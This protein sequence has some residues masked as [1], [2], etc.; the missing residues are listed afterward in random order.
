MPGPCSPCL[1]EGRACLATTE[2]NG[3]PLCTECAAFETKENSMNKID[4]TASKILEIIEGA[5]LD[6]NEVVEVIAK[7]TGWEKKTE[8]DLI[9]FDTGVENIMSLEEQVNKIKEV[10]EE[11]YRRFYQDYSGRGM[12]GR[13]CVGI[14]CPDPHKVIAEV[15]IKGAKTDS[16][17]LDSIVYWPNIKMPE[18]LLTD[19]FNAMAKASGIFDFERKLN[20]L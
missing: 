20:D 5:D 9:V 2:I 18:N 6:E 15:G 7:V 16:M 13:T 11:G 4:E 17:G 8:D 14:V 3:V 19:A 12:F 10:A 1:V